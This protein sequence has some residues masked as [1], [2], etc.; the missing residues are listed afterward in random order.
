VGLV[1]YCRSISG[2]QVGLVNIVCE[3]PL[4]CSPVVNAGF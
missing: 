3:G 2:L 4:A 1:N